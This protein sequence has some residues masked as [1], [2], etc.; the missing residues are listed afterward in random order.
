V[1][2]TTHL[3][4]LSK[5]TRKHVGVVQFDQLAAGRRRY[6]WIRKYP[7]RSRAATITYKQQL[8]RFARVVVLRRRP[9]VHADK[10][11]T[12]NMDDR[13]YPYPTCV[14]K[15]ERRKF[16]CTNVGA[17]ETMRR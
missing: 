4:S 7:E 16:S 9:Y 11:E 14:D 6:S 10:V 2:L 17:A 13:E 3:T 5:A 12:V 8:W 1:T 15:T